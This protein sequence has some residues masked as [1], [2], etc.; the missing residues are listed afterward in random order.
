MLN[1]IG[2]KVH[3]LQIG[4]FA[5]GTALIVVVVAKP[6]TQAWREALRI[7]RPGAVLVRAVA[8]LVASFCGIIAFTRLPLGDAY[9]LMFL[10]PF[11]SALLARL[12]G[13]EPPDR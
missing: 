1:G 2:G 3:V 6:R 11:L 12:L 9:A 10:A 13:G 8:G 7:Q 4:F 5:T